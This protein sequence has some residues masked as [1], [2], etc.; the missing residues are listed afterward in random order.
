[1]DVLKEI[2]QA[3]KKAREL[4]LEYEQKAQDLLSAVAEELKNKRAAADKK[5]EG[6]LSAFRAGSEKD[7]EEKKKKMLAEAKA[8]REALEK[9]VEEKRGQAVELILKKLGF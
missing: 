8:Q 7:M 3:E 9:R 6:E 4:A 1:M 5:L 2:Q